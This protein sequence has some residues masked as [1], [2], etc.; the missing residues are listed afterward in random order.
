[1]P[2]YPPSNGAAYNITPW[3]SWTPTFV[4][5]GTVANVRFFSRRVGDSLQ[6]QGIFDTGVV[7]AVNPT[8]SLGFNGTDGN[9]STDTTKVQDQSL[10]GMA[11]GKVNSTTTFGFGIL[12]NNS[13]PGTVLFTSQQSIFNILVP[14]L[15]TAAISSTATYAA[16]FVIPISGWSA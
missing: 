12:S 10:I 7:T 8:I 9:V 1:M 16:N 4:G 15:A 2:L 13:T 14:Q 3:V 6:V 11:A 5:L